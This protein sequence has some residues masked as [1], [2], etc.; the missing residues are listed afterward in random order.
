M[1]FFLKNSI[2][3][4]SVKISH[5]E[6]VLLV[7]S[8]FTENIGNKLSNFKFKTL[9]NPFG[10]IYNPISIVES[11]LRIKS[12]KPYSEPEII[13]NHGKFFSLDHH[14]S[15]SQNDK[16]KCIQKINDELNFANEFLQKINTIII[17]LG[18]AWVY[19]YTEQN[20]IVANCHK[21]PA[22]KFNKRLLS[23]EETIE[24]LVE[25]ANELSEVNII[26]SVSPVR[27]IAE[28]LHENNI[29][30]SVLHVAINHM[31][32]N[33]SNCSYFPAYEI[34][35]DELRDYRFYQQDLIHPTQQ[36]IDY[37]WKKF[38]ETFFDIPTQKLNEQIEKIQQAANHRPFD[39]ESESH[40]KF[41]KTQ[42]FNIQQLEKKIPFLNF[43]NEKLN[44]INK[45]E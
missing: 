37:V 27:H 45:I 10:I 8:C 3:P 42:L 14:G 19:E 43:E 33:Y 41:I 5:H 28:G 15:F 35:I 2:Q 22:K 20:K 23:V 12:N 24:K 31:I 1:E 29:S 16:N 13:S 38:S 39:F 26:F 7:G 17:T 40:Q 34:V 4:S 30:K 44:L 18:T 32:N 9:A 36:A 25:L 21:I 6:P 11:I